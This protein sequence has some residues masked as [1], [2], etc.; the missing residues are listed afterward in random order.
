MAERP[1]LPRAGMPEWR[2]TEA[3]RAGPCS[4]GTR[5]TRGVML[6]APALANLARGTRRGA[7][8]VVSRRVPVVAPGKAHG[9]TP[10]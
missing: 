4:A 8:Q 2:L 7:A 5:A 6:V 10:E 9:G 1:A 3:T